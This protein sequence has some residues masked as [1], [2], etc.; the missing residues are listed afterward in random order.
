MTEKDNKK[1]ENENWIHIKCGQRELINQVYSNS[2]PGK[3][4]GKSEP[5]QLQVITLEIECLHEN[6]LLSLETSRLREKYVLL[7]WWRTFGYEFFV[8]SFCVPLDS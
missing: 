2:S 6:S 8:H 4:Q 7:G 5:G 1:I 3:V